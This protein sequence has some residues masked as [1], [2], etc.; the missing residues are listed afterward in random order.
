VN[1]AQFLG[2]GV[3]DFDAKVRAVTYDYFAIN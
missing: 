1:R 2:I 3:I